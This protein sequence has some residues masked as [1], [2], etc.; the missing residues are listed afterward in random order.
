MADPL[1]KTCLYFLYCHVVFVTRCF[2]DFS[3]ITVTFIVFLKSIRAI[4]INLKSEI[5]DQFLCCFKRLQIKKLFSKPYNV[6]LFLASKTNEIPVHFHTGIAVIMKRTPHHAASADLVS[7]VLR[8]I[9][10]SDLFF[11]FPVN[12]LHIYVWRLP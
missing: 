7:I 10:C 12:I 1:V 5:F 11:N 3:N 6:T 9:P 8:H 2:S 4:C